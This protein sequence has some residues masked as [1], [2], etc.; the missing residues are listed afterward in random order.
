MKRLTH[1]VS[2]CLF[3]LFSGSDLYAQTCGINGSGALEVGQTST[4]GTGTFSG[5][6]Y[7][8]SVTGGLTINGSNSGSGVSVSGTAVDPTAQLCVTRFQEGKEPCCNCK[9][10]PVN[11]VPATSVDLTNVPNDPCPGEEVTFTASINPGNAGF[12]E[13]NFYWEGGIGSPANVPIETSQGG[14]TFTWA[15]P[16][17]DQLWV[18]VTY[19][20]CDGTKVSDLVFIEECCVPVTSLTIN[21]IQVPGQGCPGETMEF[22]IEYQP[23]NATFNVSN[24]HWFGGYGFVRDINTILQE[25]RGVFSFFFETPENGQAWVAVT[26]DDCDGSEDE[27]FVIV[28]FDIFDCFKGNIPPALNRPT[29][30]NN[31][32]PTGQVAPNPFSESTN[33]QFTLDQRAEV[34]LE[35]YDL[36]GKVFYSNVEE[37]QKGRQN[38]EISD[39][40][41]DQNGL[42]FYRLKANNKVIHTG[43][44]VRNK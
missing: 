16:A 25:E 8:W 23:P 1:L 17:G 10:I 14:K 37:F 2:L 5:A 29:G 27:A 19:T 32:P 40:P 41:A 15:T 44:L 18:R 9:T 21:Q 3:F 39:L 11:C 24:L 43:K 12:D 4:Y 28:E 36:N 42:I 38:I 26:Y 34:L 30:A 31:N 7:F 22:Q 35:L 33:L 20:S 13:S 6:S